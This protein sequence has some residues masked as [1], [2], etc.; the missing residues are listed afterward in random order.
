[1]IDGTIAMNKSL[2]TGLPSHLKI[3]SKDGTEYKLLSSPFS[4]QHDGDQI[5]SH[6]FVTTDKL[7]ALLH[8]TCCGHLCNPNKSGNSAACFFITRMESPTKQKGMINELNGKRVEKIST[9]NIFSPNFRSI[10][11]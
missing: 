8:N 2:T 3:G 1:M 6:G 10:K 7:I 5:I 11:I 4:D 9:V